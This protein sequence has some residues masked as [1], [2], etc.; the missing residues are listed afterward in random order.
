MEVSITELRTRCGELV[1][2][3]ALGH[4]ITVLMHGMPAVV[5]Q[6]VSGINATSATKDAVEVVVST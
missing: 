3:A 4:R 2:L 5:L 6:P 1:T